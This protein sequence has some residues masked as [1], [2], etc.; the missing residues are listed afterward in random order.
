M[1]TYIGKICPYCRRRFNG[2]E[3]VVFCSSCELPH[4]KSCWM[5]NGGCTSYGC[6]GSGVGVDR[7]TEIL[8][9]GAQ[10]KSILY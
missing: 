8:S 3:D 2:G 1:N 5:D 10:S 4:H 7:P 6:N 9:S